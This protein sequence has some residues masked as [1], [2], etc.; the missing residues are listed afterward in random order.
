MPI[1]Y[2]VVVAGSG[3]VGSFVAASLANKGVETALLEKN[4]ATLPICTGIIGVETEKLVPIPAETICSRINSVRM[5][6]A[7]EREL[8]Y[9]NPGTMAYVVDRQSFDH[10]LLQKAIASGVHYLEGYRVKKLSFNPPNTVVITVKNEK[11]EEKIEANLLILATGF[12]PTLLKEAGLKGYPGTVEGVQTEVELSTDTSIIEVYFSNALVPKGFLWVV[13]ISKNRAR[14]GLVTPE[15]GMKILK[16]A[17]N[18]DFLKERIKE[19][20]PAKIRMKLLPRGPIPETYGNGLLVVGEAAGQLK[21]TTYGG[22]YYGLLCGE[23]AVETALTALSLKRST[24]NVLSI[25]QTQWENRIGEEL[26]EGARWRSLFESMSDEQMILAADI[27]GGDGIFNKVKSVVKFDWHKDLIG[28]GL[29]Y[30]KRHG[31]SVVNRSIS[32][33]AS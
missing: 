10:S 7:F 3:P 13:P 32:G 17:L 16:E 1:R 33:R 4:G 25:Y 20:E 31:L 18:K 14:V 19:R 30:L 24:K 29:S 28:L 11:E 23:C 27:I 12:S 2:Q 15:K 6:V 22:I 26:R 8:V 21:A 9:S 5:N